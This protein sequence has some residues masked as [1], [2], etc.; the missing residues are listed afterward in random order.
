MTDE[1]FFDAALIVRMLVSCI[2]GI[3]IGFE[4]KN[5]AKEAGIRTHCIVACASAM[6][7]IISKYGFTDLLL[8]LETQDLRS[9]EQ[10]TR[11]DNGGGPV[12]DVG[13]RNGARRRNVCYRHIGNGN[14]SCGSASAA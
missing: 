3:A 8:E 12:G 9:A 1:I 5:R 13:H 6:M 4:R 2:C 7:M 10:Y 11:S 14:H